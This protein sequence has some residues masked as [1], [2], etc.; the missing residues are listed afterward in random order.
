MSTTASTPAI[1]GSSRAP[2]GKRSA[3][4]SLRER[5]AAIVS[6]AVAAVLGVLPHVLHHVGPLAGA[7]LLAGTGGTLLFGAIGLVAAVPF[8][9]RVHRRCGNW[10]VPA[11]LLATFAVMFSISAF[12]VGPAISSDDGGSSSSKPAPTEQ[13]A[14]GAPAKRGHEA[15]H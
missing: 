8:L 13:T 4:R 6:S 7:A 12:V 14:P 5:A 2:A 9:L 3:L 10:R 15:H 1:E 11:A